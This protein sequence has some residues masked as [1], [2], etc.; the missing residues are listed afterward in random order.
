MFVIHRRQLS[1]LA[2]VSLLPALIVAGS[3][4]AQ[5]SP[6]VSKVKSQ[7][8]SIGQNRVKTSTGVR[9]D[10]LLSA[11]RVPGRAQTATVALTTPGLAESHSWTYLLGT[12]ALTTTS[13]GAA[14]FKTAARLEPYGSLSLALTPTG[15][16]KRTLVCN[17]TNYTS[18]QREK[19]TG[20]IS[21]TTKSTGRR[22][23]GK[24]ALSGR[25]LRPSVALLTTTFGTCVPKAVLTACS[26]GITWEAIGG[27]T[28]FGTESA[29]GRSSTVVAQRVVVLARPKDSLRTDFIV[30]KEPTPKLT[31]TGSSAELTV[32]TKG[33]VMHGS[34][35]F[36]SLAAG[37]KT[38]ARCKGGID[39]FTKWKAS[40]KP[41]ALT[42]R[43]SEQIF[44]TIRLPTRHLGRIELA[45]V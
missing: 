17:A 27:L 37:K 24:V 20:R 12:R 28:L 31:T 14:T 44:G 39:T 41:G 8:L 19:V 36:K 5:P 16:A 7:S 26:T 18:V 13:K 21:F 30:A 43:A 40:F 25:S 1:Y 42:L 33:T 45:R 38:T 10:L 3:A 9:L 35:T 2:A 4:S 29:S 22:A 11:E 32:T 6:H 34:G 23:W 15:T